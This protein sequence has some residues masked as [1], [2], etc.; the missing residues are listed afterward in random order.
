MKIFFKI[1]ADPRIE[2]LFGVPSPKLSFELSINLFT[3]KLLKG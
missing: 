1:L 3:L 2:E